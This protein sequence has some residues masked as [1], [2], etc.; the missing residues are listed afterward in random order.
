MIKIVTLDGT[1][2]SGIKIK[3]KQKV[4]LRKPKGADETLKRFTMAYSPEARV[5]M[6][7]RYIRAEDPFEVDIIVKPEEYVTN[8]AVQMGASMLSDSGY[9]IRHELPSDKEGQI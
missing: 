6:V 7:K 1:K 8:R 5:N 3:G 9:A 4:V 2:I